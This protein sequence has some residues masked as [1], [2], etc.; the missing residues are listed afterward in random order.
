MPSSLPTDATGDG[1]ESGAASLAGTTHPLRLET[2]Y[3]V[4]TIPV[5]LDLIPDQRQDTPTTATGT[6]T[7]TETETTGSTISEVEAVTPPQPQHPADAWA[8]TFLSAEAEEVRAALGGV[9]V[10]FAFPSSQSSPSSSSSSNR[11]SAAALLAAVGRVVRSGLGGLDWD[12]VAL[13]VGVGPGGGEM[14]ALTPDEEEWI[15][16]LC[17]EVAG[18]G[19]EFVHVRNLGARAGKAAAEGSSGEARNEFG[20]KSL[21]A[22]HRGE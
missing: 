20:G 9:C 17:A 11:E 21:I 7:E 2:A 3:Y 19:I 18:G 12:G 22:S 6:A 4:A 8:A 14:G 13:A 5:W 16:E 15:E 1:V 10:V